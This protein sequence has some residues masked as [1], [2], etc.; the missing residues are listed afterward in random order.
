M[1][2]PFTANGHDN[3]AMPEVSAS[4]DDEV[5]KPFTPLVANPIR[6]VDFLRHV[7]EH[8]KA[9]DKYKEE[10]NVRSWLV[11]TIRLLIV[12]ENVQI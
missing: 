11:A 7:A 6:I 3:I 4:G 12:L 10:F 8:Q 1:L 9:M 5:V 2:F